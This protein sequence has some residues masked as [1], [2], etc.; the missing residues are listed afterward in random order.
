MIYVIAYLSIE[1]RTASSFTHNMQRSTF[2][3]IICSRPQLS[4][5]LSHQTTAIVTT[6]SLLHTSHRSVLLLSFPP[7]KVGQHHYPIKVFDGSGGNF[8]WIKAQSSLHH[9]IWCRYFQNITEC[10]VSLRKFFVWAVKRWFLVKMPSLM[11][12]WEYG[13]DLIPAFQALGVE[14]DRPCKGQWWNGPRCLSDKVS[15]TFHRKHHVLICLF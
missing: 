1:S 14:A 9:S 4:K 6:V 10:C 13:S 2:T 15:S 12:V 3:F 8:A 5:W 7:K 11:N